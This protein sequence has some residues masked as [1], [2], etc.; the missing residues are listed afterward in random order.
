MDFNKFNLVYSYSR[1]KQTNSISF[2][3]NKIINEIFPQNN[4]K[5]YKYN[6]I[7]AK[8][9]VIDYKSEMP[10]LGEYFIKM[11]NK[12]TIKLLN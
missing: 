6:T 8:Y 2:R 12:Q 7:V 5:K 4:K 1:G 11:N 10:I 9:K 3:K